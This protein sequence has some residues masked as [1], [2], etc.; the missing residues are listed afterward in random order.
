MKE[1]P[2]RS[3]A[4]EMMMSIGQVPGVTTIA[5]TRGPEH[6]TQK[7]AHGPKP[8][9]DVLQR[10]PQASISRSTKDWSY[11][12]R[13]LGLRCDSDDGRVTGTRIVHGA[14]LW[15]NMILPA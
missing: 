1:R 3:G 8:V 9:L 10:F 15:D 4:H 5:Y 2:H 14:R 11:A 7:L 12:Q 13:K 6:H